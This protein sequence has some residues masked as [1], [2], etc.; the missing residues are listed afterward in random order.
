[1]LRYRHAIK[2]KLSIVHEQRLAAG[3]MTSSFDAKEVPLLQGTPDAPRCGFSR[4]VVEA[5]RGNEVQDWGSFDI[6]Q[7][8]L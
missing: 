1:M 8:R 4:K 5:L 3:C 2:W 7:V 6:L